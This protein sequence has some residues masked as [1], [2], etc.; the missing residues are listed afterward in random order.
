MAKLLNALAKTGLEITKFSP[1]ETAR[2]TM[3][4]ERR[5]ED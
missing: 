1:A 2:Y 4:R 5:C 3:D